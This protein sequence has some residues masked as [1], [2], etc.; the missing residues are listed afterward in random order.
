MITLDLRTE[1]VSLEEL[2]QTA[3][4]DAVRIIAENGQEYIFEKTD[5]FLKTLHKNLKNPYNI[6]VEKESKK[7]MLYAFFDGD[8]IGPTVE[9]LLTENKISEAVT[10]S[11]NVAAAMLAIDKLL[12]STDGVKIIILGGDDILIE[13]DPKKN[14]LEFLEKIRKIF[15]EKTGNSM[16]CGIGADL[17]QSIWQLHIAKLYGKNAIKGLE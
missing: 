10:F 16:S 5:N 11:E 2:L 8:N 7:T 12:K 3:E 13:F 9:I 17:P 15:K 1:Q 4:T 14:G 6:S